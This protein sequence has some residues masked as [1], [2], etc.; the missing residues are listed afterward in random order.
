MPSIMS[1]NGCAQF[2]SSSAAFYVTHMSMSMLLWEIRLPLLR[3]LPCQHPVAVYTLYCSLKSKQLQA[4]T[5]LPSTN[6][7]L[8]H[9]SSTPLENS[10]PL[11]NEA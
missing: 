8:E 5:Q 10:R 9:I 2:S 6:M 4:M 11:D 1:R 7:Y 3:V